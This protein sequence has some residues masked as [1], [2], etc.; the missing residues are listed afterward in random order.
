M[1]SVHKSSF[2]LSISPPINI[3]ISVINSDVIAGRG[4]DVIAHFGDDISITV[5]DVIGSY[6]AAAAGERPPFFDQPRTQQ[7]SAPTGRRLA[8]APA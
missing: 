8:A 6:T 1:M 7:A 5:S 2:P 3:I 4:G